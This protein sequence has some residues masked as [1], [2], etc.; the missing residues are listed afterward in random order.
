MR[1]QVE[2]IRSWDEFLKLRESWDDLF[3]AMDVKN[4]FLSWSWVQTWVEVYGPSYTPVIFVIKDK[5][6]TIGIVPFYLD[7]RLRLGFSRHGSLRWVGDQFVSS[8]FLDALAP[9]YQKY[10]VWWNVINGLL[11]TNEIDW[12]F[13]FLDDMLDTNFSVQILEQLSKKLAIGYHRT[14]KNILPVLFLPRNW[15]EWVHTHPNTAFLS[16]TRNRSRRLRKKHTIEIHRI[17][18]LREFDLAVE[19]FFDLHQKNW[20]SRGM[21]GSFATEEKREFYRRMGR[22]F[23]E[24]GWLQFRFSYLDGRPATAEFGILLDNVYY[25]LQSGYDPE[26]RKFNMGHFLLYEIVQWLVNKGVERIEFL[27]GDEGYKFKWGAQKRYSVTQWVGKR[28]LPGL[29]Y[30]LY[31]KQKHVFKH[32]LQGVFS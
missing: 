12:S 4:P 20:R 29:A 30:P 17:R 23:L 19:I 10:T 6:H 13:L 15:E 24:N 28:N 25:S 26:F 16:M 18:S 9:H 1:A 22:R 14:V 2:I 8:E 7:R 3:W 11:E 5:D 27:R 32:L 31:K 21:P